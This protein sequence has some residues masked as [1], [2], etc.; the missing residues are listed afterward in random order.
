MHPAQ[1]IRQHMDL[2]LNGL[3]AAPPVASSLLE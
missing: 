1:F 3:R 2:V